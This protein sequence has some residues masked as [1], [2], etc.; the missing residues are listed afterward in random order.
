MTFHPRLSFPNLSSLTVPRSY[1]LGHHSA[2]LERMRG[3]VSTMDVIVEVRDYR[4]PLTSRNPL[5]EQLVGS[6]ARVVVYTK[7]DLGSTGSA[8]D[9]AREQ[10]IARWAQK[11]AGSGSDHD[12]NG[13]GES[14][15][16]QQVV[17][18]CKRQHEAADNGRSHLFGTRV[19]VVGMPNVGKSTLPG[20]T[21]KV[22]TAIKIVM[23]K[24][25]VCGNVKDGIVPAVTMADYLLYHVNLH[26]PD[27]YGAWSEPTNEI[28]Q[29][30]G[31]LA[32]RQGRLKK[33]GEPDYEAAALQFIQ[34]WRAGHLGRFVL[35]EVSDEAVARREA[36]VQA[37][38]GSWNQARRAIKMERKVQAAARA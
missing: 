26:A 30:L 12:N 34:K 37:M 7:R 27:S 15:G 25:A 5:F 19:L 29:V 35:D 18:F 10:I 32:R 36:L 24:L 14:R 38:G 28:G 20:V 4:T 8:A 16:V 23:L 2:G 13:D 11:T 17:D 22:G 31:G 6:R 9:R 21:R 33:G 3:L 1:F